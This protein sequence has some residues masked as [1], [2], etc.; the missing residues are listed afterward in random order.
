MGAIPQSVKMTLNA[1]IKVFYINT[2]KS[3]VFH[4]VARKA[5]KFTIVHIISSDVF[6]GGYSLGTSKIYC[7]ATF[8]SPY[9]KICAYGF[10]V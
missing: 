2:W 6:N 1:I 10:C 3:L 4:E 7:L 5:P 9:H 8:V